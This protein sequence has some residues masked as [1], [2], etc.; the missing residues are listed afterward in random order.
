MTTFIAQRLTNIAETGRHLTV[1]RLE[2]EI[3]KQDTL[4]S[5]AFWEDA[6]EQM[7][8]KDMILNIAELEQ[9]K[10]LLFGLFMGM[11]DMDIW[12]ITTY[13]LQNT[14][15]RFTHYGRTVSRENTK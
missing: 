9:R 11:T 6:V 10:L 8:D 13:Y 4:R 1:G 5:L 7:V 15:L 3:F 14:R 2:K 12:K